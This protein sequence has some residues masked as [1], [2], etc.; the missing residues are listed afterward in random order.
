MLEKTTGIV[1]KTIK[2]GDTSLIANI[3][4]EKFGLQAYILKGVR[5]GKS[6]AQKAQ[7]FFSGSILDLV[8]Y[9]H[10]QKNLHMTKEVQVAYV[11]QHLTGSILKNGIALFAMEVLLQ[12]LQTE[13]VQEELF[14]FCLDFLQ[15]LD[16][17]QNKE[18]ANMPLFFLIQAGRISGYHISGHYSAQYPFLDLEEGRFSSREPNL[19]PFIDENDAQIMSRLNETNH[20]E[21]VHFISI[22][23][24]TRKR[25]MDYYIGFFQRHAPQFKA[26]RSNAILSAILN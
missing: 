18:L 5:G 23:N 25:I 22:T 16:G 14:A 12:L 26:L 19:P 4:T 3:F 10:P 8:V 17:L 15:K 2:Y 11:Y 20:L 9:Y 21:K 7:L 1:L 13:E 6:K 24:E